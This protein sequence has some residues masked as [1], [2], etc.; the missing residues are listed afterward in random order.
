M[1]DINLLPVEDKSVENLT[2]LQKKATFA[3][4]AILLITAIATVATLVMFTIYAGERNKINAQISE[5]TGKIEGLKQVEGLLAFTVKKA[6]AAQKARD[7][8][9][10]Y[11]NFF[12]GFSALIPQGVFFNDIKI[13]GTKLTLSGKAQSSADIAGFVSSIVSE[14]GQKVLV[15]ANID[16]LNS[17]TKGVYTFTMSAEAVQK[18]PE[19]GAK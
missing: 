19:G 12:D 18:T 10:N 2:D 14:N 3:S 4:F 1:A 13:S 16:T 7:L 11:T 15:G 8:R 5:N 6:V 17:D 9:F